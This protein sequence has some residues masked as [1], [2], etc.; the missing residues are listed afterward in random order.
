MEREQ[1]M[2]EVGSSW[3]QLRDTSTETIAISRTRS[4]AR[5]AACANT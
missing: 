2:E 4:H 3:S 1:A 5:G